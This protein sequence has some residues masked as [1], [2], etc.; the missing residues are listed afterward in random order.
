MVPMIVLFVSTLIARIFVPWKDAF[1]VGLAVMFFFTAASHFAPSISRDLAAMIPP[2]LTGAMWL[3][4]ATGVME[5]VGAIGL[6]TRR[7]RRPAAICLA[8][9]L[10]AMFPANVY[11]V[12]AGVPLRGAAATP[13]WLRT[14]MQLFWI[15]LLW[16]TTIRRSPGGAPVSAPALS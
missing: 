1:R 4:Y 15:A 10:V 3:I 9:L 11:A 7:F 14:P 16:W 2:P 8:L 6:L 5:I 13:L 12:I